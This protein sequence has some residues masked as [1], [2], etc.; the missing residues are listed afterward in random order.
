M[1]NEYAGM[2]VGKQVKVIKDLENVANETEGSW[3]GKIGKCVRFSRPFFI[4]DFPDD[5][6]PADLYV[7]GGLANEAWFVDSELEVVGEEGE[8]G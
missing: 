5:Q 7:P 8:D 6:V 4:V 2:F 1:D 3:V